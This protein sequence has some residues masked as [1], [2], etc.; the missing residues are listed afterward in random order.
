MENLLYRSGQCGGRVGGE[1]FGIVA[2]VSAPCLSL[3]LVTT[4]QSLLCFVSPPHLLFH[5]SFC[6]HW[7]EWNNT[8]EIHTLMSKML[9]S[10]SGKV[11][12]TN[13]AGGGMAAEEKLINPHTVSFYV[14][15]L[16]SL[17]HGGVSHCLS[18]NFDSGQ[19]RDGGSTY[20]TPPHGT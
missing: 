16:S 2:C 17:V 4:L 10:K 3:L 14:P 11:K 15:F 6:L 7:R 1:S 9:G 18:K 5:S 20:G 8:S 12:M 13:V 19:S